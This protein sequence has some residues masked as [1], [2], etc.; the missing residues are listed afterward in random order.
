MEKILAREADRD[1][2]FEQGAL[3]ANVLY[4]RQRLRASCLL[5]ARSCRGYT[6]KKP[7][8]STWARWYTGATELSIKLSIK[9]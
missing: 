4:L 9:H 1:R 6:V 3:R 5:R 8:V 2:F 7:W